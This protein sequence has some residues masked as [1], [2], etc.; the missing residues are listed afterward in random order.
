MK[1]DI[2]PSWQAV[3]QPD[4]DMP[5]FKTLT[6]RVR[7]AYQTSVV[8]PPAGL[9]FNAFNLTPFDE[10]KVVI[11]GQDPYHNP[12]QAMG[13]SFSVPEGTPLPPSLQNIFKEASAD[14]QLPAPISG[15]LT[16]WAEQGVLLLN[17]I[18]T[19][20]AHQ[21]RS[22]HP[23]GWQILTD[24]VIELLNKKREGI[25]F[26]LWGSDAQRK[27]GQIDSTKHLVL[28][29]PHPSPLSAYRGFFGTKPFS[30][31]NYYLTSRG[32]RPIQ[33]IK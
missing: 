27:E 31:T 9:I 3:L 20:Q 5:Y 7:E 30:Q 1:V 32:K 2:H 17:S 11:L 10:V 12:G 18:L 13:L 33:W 23:F 29:A 14:L 24:K 16:H 15:D 21:P 8:Y 6:D 22:H 28:K 26:I 19:V 25:V 4:F